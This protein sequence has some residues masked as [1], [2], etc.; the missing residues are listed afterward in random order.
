MRFRAKRSTY[1]SSIS[2]PLHRHTHTALIPPSLEPVSRPPSSCLSRYRPAQCATIAL[3]KL[4]LLLVVRG[5]GGAPTSLSLIP[6]IISPRPFLSYLLGLTSQAWFVRFTRLRPY[7]RKSQGPRLPR[8]A[9]LRAVNHVLALAGTHFT[10][11]A[12]FRV[13]SGDIYLPKKP[14]TVAGSPDEYHA[15]GVPQISVNAAL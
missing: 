13:S 12:S 15:S 3:A 11:W 1:R 2:N 8:N 6:T 5:T 10:L 14:T 4:S 9:I 7:L